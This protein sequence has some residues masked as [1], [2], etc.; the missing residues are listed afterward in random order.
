MRNFPEIKIIFPEI[1]LIFPKNC[2][3][4]NIEIYKYCELKQIWCGICAYDTDFSMCSNAQKRGA[5]WR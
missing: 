4:Y 5:L 1:N 2:V 3:I